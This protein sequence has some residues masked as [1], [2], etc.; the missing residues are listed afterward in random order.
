MENWL[1]VGEVKSEERR[2]VGSLSDYVGKSESG[3]DEVAMV[4]A[5]RSNG[6]LNIL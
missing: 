3:L 5:E 6:I 2:A 4:E 1:R